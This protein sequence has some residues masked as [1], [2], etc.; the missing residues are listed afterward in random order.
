LLDT[1]SAAVAGR[2]PGIRLRWAVSTPGHDV[3]ELPRALNEARTAMDAARRLGTAEACFYDELGV[4]RLLV[5]GH[6]DPDLKEFVAAVTQPLLDYDASHD[7][8]LLATLRAFFQAE[9]S[10]RAAAE[11]LFIHHKTLRYRL[12]QIRSLTGLDLSRH[13]DRVR[14]DLAL[15]LLEATRPER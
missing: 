5:G 6:E 13:S 3:L 10:Q 2:C 9:C 15:Q 4:V 7:G 14:A 12:E 8:A 1:L 11:R